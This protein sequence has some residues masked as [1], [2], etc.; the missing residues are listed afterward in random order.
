[1]YSVVVMALFSGL[2]SIL[3]LVLVS[4]VILAWIVVS[5]LVAKV[6]AMRA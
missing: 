2:R 5:K 3:E 6:T 4:Y 1:M